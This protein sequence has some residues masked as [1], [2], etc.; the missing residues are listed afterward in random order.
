M[1]AAAT[2]TGVA[3]VGITTAVQG[4]RSAGHVLVRSVANNGCASQFYHALGSK[5]AMRAVVA[6]SEWT[7]SLNW[8]NT[9]TI[10]L[11][12]PQV[13]AGAAQGAAE[14]QGLYQNCLTFVFDVIAA[15][16]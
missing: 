16:L 8:W 11:R 10:P 6:S 2:A 12:N 3:E 9:I 7:E 5:G 4:G 1:Y 15:G 14:A 13:A